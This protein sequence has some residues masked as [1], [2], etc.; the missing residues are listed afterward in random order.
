MLKK[1]LIFYKNSFHD[2]LEAIYNLTIFLPYFFSVSNLSKTL[3]FPWKNLSAKT[4]KGSFSFQALL[5]SFFFNFISRFIGFVMRLSIIIFYLFTQIVF[6]TC[7]PLL[8]IFYMLWLPFLFLGLLFEKTEEEKK[9]KLK[10]NFVNQHLIR[11][12]NKIKVE[13][14]FEEYYAAH[15][16]RLQWWKIKN[17]FSIPPLARDWASGYTPI[18]NDYCEELTTSSYQIKTKNIIDREKEIDQIERVLIQTNEA[19]VIVVGEEGVGKHTII[20]ALAKRIYEGQT[21]TQLVYKRI[22]KLNM[23]KIANQYIDQKQRE[24][25]FEE[26]FQEAVEATNV[27]LLIDDIDKYLSYS[28]SHID[29]SGPIEKFTRNS[30]IQIIGITNPFHYQKYIYSNDKIMHFFKKVDVYEVNKAEAEKII[31]AAF[32]IFEKNYKVI[33]PYETIISII[34]KSD[35]YI[36][37]IPFPEKAIDLLDSAC[38]Y[39][40]EKLK[41]TVVSEN[42]IEK[43]L[44]E[45]THAPVTLDDS[46]RQ[47]LVNLEKT[48]NEKIIA[49]PNAISKVSSALRRAFL[50][51]GKRKKPLASFL[52]FGPTGVGKT[53]TAKTV[54]KIIFGSDKNL[55]RFDM[56][57][58]Q[59]K[60]DIPKLIGSIETHEP[61]LMTKAIREN[62]FTVL[63][64]DEI[65]KADKDLIN[66]FLSLIDE[67]YF[68]DGMGKRVDCKNL[69]VI[70]TSNAA[71]D[72]IFK[73]LEQ[74]ISLSTNELINYLVEKNIFSPEFLNR[75]DGVIYYE[76][77]D[78]NSIILLSKIIIDRI[79]KDIYSLYRV[80]II[81]ADNFIADIAQKSYDQKFGARNMERLIRETIE[82][83]L[84]K[85][86]LTKKAREGDTVHL[87]ANLTI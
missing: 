86:I 67:G 47:K 39:T 46:V 76:P 27:I 45:K 50:L 72:F 80:K 71:S 49:Q 18:L 68:T 48:L 55:I 87:G 23:E 41:Q 81:I 30:L 78:L 53:E 3:F 38:V 34:E 21:S 36:T 17:L 85:I 65:E 1:L 15:I 32:Y 57:L 44:A 70:A 60:N 19:N 35:F 59:S 24:N 62:P 16:H 84:S 8:L 29:F 10:T 4:T 40:T 79:A 25:F 28:E 20:D 83:E 9:Q 14:W 54:S 77:L 42:I 64:L 52:F 13:E 74:K 2:F 22:L 61:G 43:V 26:L 73:S 51:V 82:D 31:R 63:L 58:Y 5:D 69:I 33:I 12:E 37:H 6:L 56:S 75:F 7:I 11:P 66:I